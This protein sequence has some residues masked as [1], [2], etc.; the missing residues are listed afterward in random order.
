M[1]LSHLTA[2]SGQ[3]G[4]SIRCRCAST[5]PQLWA[6]LP[7]FKGLGATPYLDDSFRWR[8]VR[9]VL[10]FP[11]PAYC[12][13]SFA[14]GVGKCLTLDVIWASA[15]LGLIIADALRRSWDAEKRV[16]AKL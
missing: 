10:A 14:A 13:G 3:S 11:R 6:G 2:A 12:D 1:T 15:P 16:R 5:E 4:A 9:C 8:Y 7:L